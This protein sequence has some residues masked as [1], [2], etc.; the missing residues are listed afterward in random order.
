MVLSSHHSCNLHITASPADL[1]KPSSKGSR[2]PEN[3]GAMMSNTLLTYA[4]IKGI[5]Q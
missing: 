2:R 1:E 4:Y 5:G 3:T